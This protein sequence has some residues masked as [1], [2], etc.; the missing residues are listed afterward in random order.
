MYVD[1]YTCVY[2][3][4]QESTPDHI[5]HDGCGQGK[6]EDAG[7]KLPIGVKQHSDVVHGP[8]RGR[9]NALVSPV[10]S[11]TNKT[12]YH[13][14]MMVQHITKATMPSRIDCKRSS[15]EHSIM[16]CPHSGFLCFELKN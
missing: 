14:E 10:C 12:L 3:W 8:L 13:S 7:A 2:A 1:I 16:L 4:K 9:Y 11:R 5:R 15:T 6:R